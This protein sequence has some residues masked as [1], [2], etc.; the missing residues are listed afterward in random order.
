VL[1]APL[2]RRFDAT[3][4]ENALLRQIIAMLNYAEAGT[5]VPAICR[6]TASAVPVFIS[7]I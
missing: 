3:I 7:N 6:G 4:M 1:E 5:L 2:V